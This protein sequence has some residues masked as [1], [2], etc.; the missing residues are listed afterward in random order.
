MPTA[1]A[2]SAPAIICLILSVI[3][4]EIYAHVGVTVTLLAGMMNVYHVP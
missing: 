4:N 2:M 3:A 1:T